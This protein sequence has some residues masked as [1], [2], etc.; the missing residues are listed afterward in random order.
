M[1][2]NSISLIVLVLIHRFY[3]RGSELSP[4]HGATISRTELQGNGKFTI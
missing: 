2:F 3:V 4:V 1:K